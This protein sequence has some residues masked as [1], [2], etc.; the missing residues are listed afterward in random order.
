MKR[1]SMLLKYT[2]T[3]VTVTTLSVEITVEV[4][5]GHKCSHTL[6][7]LNSDT[8]TDG[9]HVQVTHL[10]ICFVD[11]HRHTY[12]LHIKNTSFLMVFPDYFCSLNSLICVIFVGFW[13]CSLLL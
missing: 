5:G 7:L 13:F 8:M 2:A 12:I 1:Y 10:Q 3:Y 11:T 6:Q 9:F 4:T